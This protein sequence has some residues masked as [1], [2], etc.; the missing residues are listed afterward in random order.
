MTLGHILATTKL[1]ALWKKKKTY[2]ANT[3]LQKNGVELIK[4]MQREFTVSKPRGGPKWDY[5][6]ILL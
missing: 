5:Y 1:R 3:D 2:D 4:A 6:Y